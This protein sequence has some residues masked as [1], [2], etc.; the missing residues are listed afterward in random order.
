MRFDTA[1]SGRVIQLLR[2][3][4]MVLAV[5]LLTGCPGNQQADG[6]GTIH[7]EAKLDG[8]SWSG[9][10]NYDVTDLASGTAVPAT[11]G[12]VPVGSYTLNYHSGGPSDAEFVGVTPAGTQT[13][14]DGRSITFTMEF[15]TREV[16]RSNIIVRATLRQV[17]GSTVTWMGSVGFRLTGP[18]TILGTSVPHVYNGMPAG[19]Y[20]LEYVSGGPAGATLLNVTPSPN[21]V[22]ST[23][24][25]VIFT[26]EFG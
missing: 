26:L 12:N 21:Q 2:S 17:D 11:H 10:V 25:T 16:A 3:L 24:D 18:E 1:S 4:L 23:G 13:V 22:L 20:S 8:S 14:T 9:P 19:E 5:L 6:T 15:R 7:V